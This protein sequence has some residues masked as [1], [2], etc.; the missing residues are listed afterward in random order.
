MDV[1]Y[2][3]EAHGVLHGAFDGC[4]NEGTLLASDCLSVGDVFADMKHVFRE[5]FLGKPREWDYKGPRRKVSGK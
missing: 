5:C 2:P 1:E 3:H 4:R